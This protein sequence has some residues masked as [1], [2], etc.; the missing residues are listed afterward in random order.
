MKGLTMKKII[1]SLLC[2]GLIATTFTACSSADSFSDKEQLSK[3]VER[4]TDTETT[5]NYED[6]AVTAPTEYNSFSSGVSDF[7]LKLFRN[8]YKNNSDKKSFV[9]APA[10][11]TLTLGLMAN[12][13]AKQSQTN[14]VNA[15]SDELVIDSLNQCSSYFQSRLKAFSSD[16]TADENGKNTEKAYVKLN[17]SYF[18]NDTV[19]I[20]KNF[21]TANANYYGTDIFRFVFSDQNAVKKMNSVLGENAI[22][23]LDN[24]NNLLCISSSDMYDEWLNAYKDDAVADG[25]FYSESGEKSVKYMTSV[26]NYIH[27]D[28]AQGVIKYMRNTPVKFAMIMPNE[29]TSLESYIS[30]MTYLEYSDLLDSFKITT[31]TNASIP[32]FSITSDSTPKS[33][34]TELEDCGLTDIFTDSINLSNIT[35]SDDLFVN[36]IS[37]IQPSITVNTSGVGGSEKVKATVVAN[38][39][40][41]DSKTADSTLKFDRPFIFMLIDNE[42]NIPLY[43]GTVDF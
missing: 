10:N 28:K 26:E 1:S 40:K 20:R 43:I 30:S 16:G 17:Q 19:D 36:D 18:F 34:K 3:G 2:A 38:T 9:F 11:T 32:E 39:L 4:S 37:E 35:L 31:L 12:G 15:L 24:S 41:S 5:F 22:T 42:S 27:T 14:I 29:D 23:S 6:G 13:A 8:Y 33:L 7:E 21:L 25:T